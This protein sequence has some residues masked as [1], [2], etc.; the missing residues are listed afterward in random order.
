MQTNHVFEASR[1]ER[2]GNVYFHARIAGRDSFLTFY[3]PQIG[4]GLSAKLK[5]HFGNMSAFKEGVFGLGISPAS[6][7][8]V[9][10]YEREI[11][12]RRRLLPLHSAGY[13]S[14]MGMGNRV[15]ISDKDVPTLGDPSA[16]AG[17]GSSYQSTVGTGIPSWFIQQSIARELLPEGVRAEDHPGIGHTGGYGPRELLRAGLFAF[18]AQGGYS[19]QG[20]DIGADADHAIIAGRNDDEIQASLALNKLAMS[21]A[22]EYTKFTV[23]T[24]QLFDYPVELGEARKRQLIATFARRIFEIPNVN[25]GEPDYVFTFDEE[26]ILALGRKYWRPLEIHRELFDYCLE[27]K[28]DTPFDYELSLDETPAPAPADELLFYLVA[29]EEIFDIPRG[30][31]SSAGPNIGYFKRSDYKGDVEKDLYPLANACASIMAHRGVAFSVHSGDGASPFSGRGS[32]VDITVGKATGR[33]MELKLSD[34]YQEILWHAMAYSDIPSEHALFE[35]V[36]ETTR[37]ATAILARAYEELVEGK[38]AEESERLLRDTARLAA[39]GAAFGAPDDAIRLIKGVLHY[40]TGQLKYAHHYLSLAD[41]ENRRP[42]DEF[43]RRFVQY[44]YPTVRGPIYQ[45]LSAATWDDYEARCR[46]YTHMRMRD[47]GFI[48]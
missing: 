33:K 38:S 21:E 7:E 13:Q 25:A 5:G 39:V 34:I 12:P 48:G 4:P 28:G 15:V 3:D 32:A 19:S 29:L 23:D 30:R 31:V 35:W 36:W 18:G 43:F 20:F 46:S 37:Q 26:R 2:D 10:A 22:R 40:G 6:Y 14:T 24:S 42:T 9:L 41:A 44:V 1:L 27:L 11:A 17:F 47:L 8:N 45:T 16:L